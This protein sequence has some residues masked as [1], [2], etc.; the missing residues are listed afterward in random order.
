[1]R[2]LFSSVRSGAARTVSGVFAAAMLA[3]SGFFAP[4][5]AMTFS[6]I[7]IST[8]C[9]GSGCPRAVI[10]HGEISAEA[11]AEFS[12]FL[13]EEMQMPGL[14][15]VVFL[16]SP[17]GNVE[18]ALKLGNLFHSAGAA[19]VVG[20]PM[21]GGGR[22]RRGAGGLGVVPGHCASACVYALMGARKRVV[23]SGAR[24]GVHRMSA[25][26][27][28]LEPAGGGKRTDRVFAGLQEIDALRSYVA[29]VGGSQDLITL[30]ES[31]PH[32]QIHVLS[33]A[34]VRR[35]RLGSPKL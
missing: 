35:Y 17:G 25:R 29:R 23:P 4:A 21:L 18:S 16:N 5:S 20:Q 11:P 14:H 10:A 6:T 9:T 31:I 12:A 2:M 1:M 22:T 26:M 3:G 28:A 8:E 19:V 34:E 7:P 30:A 13:Q 32:D 33:A 27:M 24:V 15:A